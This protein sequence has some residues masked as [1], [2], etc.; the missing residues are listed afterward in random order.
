MRVDA[1]RCVEPGEPLDA[2]ERTFGRGDVPARDEDP[3]EPG[4]PGSADD[5]VRVAL[6]S[7]GVQMAM[8]VDEGRQER[9]S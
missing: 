7:V 8:A 3:L 2:G 1:D 4:Q 9:V 6:E 5:L